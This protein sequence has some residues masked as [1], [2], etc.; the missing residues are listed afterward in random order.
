MAGME[1]NRFAVRH[2]LIGAVLCQVVT[3]GVYAGLSGIFGC[4]S[5]RGNRDRL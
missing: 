5:Q 3:T 1:R 4:V 2:L